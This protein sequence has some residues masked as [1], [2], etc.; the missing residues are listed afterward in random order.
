ME[1]RSLSKPQIVRSA[2]DR[3]SKQAILFSLLALIILMANT[4]A[5]AQSINDG[6]TPAG[7]A[8][9]SPAGSYALSGVE[10]VN[11]FNG[12]LSFTLPLEKIAGRGDA[13]G[14]IILPIESR[15]TNFFFFQSPGGAFYNP[16]PQYNW[17]LIDGLKPGYG[18]GVLLLRG[19]NIKL[20]ECGIEETRQVRSRITFVT[21]SGTEFE[22]RDTIHEGAPVTYGGC[23]GVYSPVARGTTFVTADGTAATFISDTAIN[24]AAVH[25]VSNWSFKS[26]D[27]YGYLKMRDGTHYRIDNGLVSWMRDR[28]GNQIIYTYTND[29]VTLIKDSLGRTTAIEYGI[30]DVA[31][32]G[33]CDRIT[34]KGNGG[35]TRI[36]RVSYSLLSSTLASGF[37][38]RPKYQL[39]PPVN[40][41]NDLPGQD[42]TTN[43]D[44]T[45]VSSVWLPD[46][47]RYKFLYNNYAELAR[48]ELP[49]GGSFEY[50]W[51]SGPSCGCNVLFQDGEILRRVKERRI[52]NE[53][54]T[55]QKT[56]YSFTA[57][58]CDQSQNTAVT[59]DNFDGSAQRINREQHFFFGSPAPPPNRLDLFNESAWTQG[60]EYQ[61]NLYAADSTTLLRRQI[62]TWQHRASVNWWV[63]YSCT[64]AN[65]PPNDP[66]IVE[67][68]TTLADTGQVSKLTS[69]DPTDLS[70]QTVGFDQFNNKTDVWEYDFGTGAAGAFLRRSHTDYVT[71]TNYIAYTGSH[72]RSLPLQMWVSSD[73]NGNTKASLTQFEYDNYNYDTNHAALVPRSNVI[74]H[75]TV[76][77][78][79]TNT[80]R[81]NVTSVTSY[82]NAQAQTGAITAYAQFDILGNVVKTIDAK[83]NA[84]MI[85]YT[86]RFGSP[87]GE[88]R[89]NTAPTQLNGQSTFAFPTSATNP[90][91]W[92]T[93]YSQVDYFTGASVNTEDINGVISKTLYND[94]LDRPTQSVSAVGTAFERQSNIVYDDANRRIET[95][96][97]LAALNDNLI[98]AE[99][100]YDGLGRTTEARSYKDGG[101]VAV[102]TEFDALGRP[103]RVTNP[104]RPLLNEP[105]LWTESFYDSLGRVVKIRTPDN[106]EVNTSYSGN[107]VTVTDQAGKQRRSITNALGQLTRVDE[108]TDAGGLG[109]VSSPNQPTNYVYDLLNNL[110]TVTQGVQTRNFTYNSLSRLSNATNPESGL[111]QYVYD[112]NGNLTSKTDARSITTSYAYDALNRVLTRNYSD[113]TTPNVAYT[114]D[115]LPNAKGRLTKVASSV[116]TTEYTGFDIMG[117][118]TSSKQTT[119]G[120]EYGGVANPMTYTYNLAGALT[121]QQYPSGR[122]VKNILNQNGNL[123]IVESKKNASAGYFNYAKNFTYSAAGAVTSMQLG[124]NRWESTVFNSRLQPTQINLGTTQGGTDKLNLV[125]GY[126]STQNNGNV[127]SQTIT[128]PTVGSNTGFTAIQNYTYDELNRLKT[129]T[130]TI[131]GSQTWTQ[132]YGFDRYGNRNITSGTGVTS[133]SF[134]NN[135]ITTH[136]Y[137]AAGNTLADGTGKTF[138]YDAENKQTAVNGGSVG[139]YWYDGDGKRVKKYVPS[140][141]ETTVFVY[142]AGGKLVAE[143]STIVYPASTAKVAYVTNDHLGS[144]RINTDA[145][146][147]VTSRHDYH[148]FGEEILTTQRTTALNYAADTVRKQF[149]TYERDG[150]TGLDFAQARYDSS[151]LGRFTS[152]DPLM[153]SAKRINPQTFNRYSYVTNNPLNLV[154]PL[155]MDDCPAGKTC[156][157]PCKA[158]EAGCNTDLSAPI[159]TVQSERPIETPLETTLVALSTAI[160][161]RPLLPILTQGVSSIAVSVTV[162]PAVLVGG[163][164]LALSGTANPINCPVNVCAA[165]TGPAIETGER[166]SAPAIP[167][168]TTQDMPPPLDPNLTIVRGG[169]SPLPPP[170]TVFSGAF[171]TSIPDAA[172]FVPHGQ[173][174]ATTV[175]AILET[176]GTVVPVPEM[177]R[178]GDLNLRHVNIT[179]GRISTFSPPMPNPVPKANRIQ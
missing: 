107:S 117:R 45:V 110:T 85:D 46:D 122:V 98:K 125:Y 52:K 32:Y 126:G 131:G 67:T 71:D 29:R 113:G 123:S 108:P 144:P 1:G 159:A 77:Y 162:P 16:T 19:E 154:D 96:S 70:G 170:G 139:Q 53:S 55:E 65:A 151:S 111:I 155:G 86:D 112:N 171:G 50:D 150:E 103:K 160:A 116:S 12:N 39:F 106:A 132:V 44:T 38:L 43:F 133:L 88:A 165:G 121:E 114:Y 172:A 63:C 68:V 177:T 74:G 7:F 127:Q 79:T 135:K 152:P 56:T 26:R 33:L 124:N 128:V 51:E 87:D 175:R 60:K 101:Y 80:R 72:L 89:S 136:S 49:T 167:T 69:I 99:S 36:I 30:N 176:G 153:A 142:D 78:G 140:S 22:L 20:S 95:K 35:Q 57:P 59:V 24:D 6:T 82:A 47:K 37:S 163:A 93:G 23:S 90:L 54:I 174:R 41:A 2:S 75:D 141:G 28:N 17:D 13:Q 169:E 66:R 97:D 18:P 134:S 91:G 120:V 83:G 84:S 179:Q 158:G 119:D 130:E 34:F 76:N 73:T 145:N 10:N 31:P 11:L 118:V 148:P 146:G 9:G 166:T 105:Q 15:W 42:H 161:M 147:L 27:L 3:M 138:T 102:K 109:T 62:Q 157:V 115:N 168:T 173:I 137:D 5:V 143:Y 81:G 4:S 92:V 100:F 8:P 156:T 14:T 149:T 48:A 61:S 40:P 178:G 58:S 129:A 94:P 25:H 164:I 64:P 104:Y 21:P